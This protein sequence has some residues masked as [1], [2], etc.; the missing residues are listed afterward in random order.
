MCRSDPSGLALYTEMV[1]SSHTRG[2]LLAQFP[3][4]ARPRG[5]RNW[6]LAREESHGSSPEPTPRQ[7][8]RTST[9]KSDRS[10]V[11]D[12]GVTQ[13]ESTA[14]LWNPRVYGNNRARVYVTVA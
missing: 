6:V 2:R 13:P 4:S 12:S 9:S 14:A 5:T 11:S 10:R 8:R 1:E 3:A 7:P